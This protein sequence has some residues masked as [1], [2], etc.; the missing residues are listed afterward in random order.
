MTWLRENFVPADME[1]FWLGQAK[2]TVGN[3][4]SML[5]R[6]VKFRKQIAEKIGVGFLYW[7]GRVRMSEATPA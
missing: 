1:R 7:L 2:R 5:K 6:N 4:Y 3:D